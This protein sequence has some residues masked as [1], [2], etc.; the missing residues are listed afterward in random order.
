MSRR[1]MNEE[2]PPVTRQVINQTPLIN[3]VI[4]LKEQSKALLR[5]NASTRLEIASFLRREDVQP[6]TKTS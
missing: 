6:E 2:A 1:R 3:M 5:P 4:G